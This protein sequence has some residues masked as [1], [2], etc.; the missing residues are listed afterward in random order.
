MRN[1]AKMEPV[2]VFPPRRV[3]IIKPSALGD[4]VTGMPILRGLRRSF[5]DAHLAWLIASPLA[6]VIAHDSDLDEVILFDRERLGKAWRSPGAAWA[7]RRLLRELKRGAFDWVIDLQGL[8]RS[9]LFAR[10]TRA[11]VRAGFADAREGAALFYTHRVPATAT[12][13]V[14]RNVELARALGVDAKPSDMTLQ[15]SGEARV[16]AEE[17]LD[18]EGLEPGGFWV[19]VAPTRWRTKLYPVRHWRK[20]AAEMARRMPVALL[21]APGDR[22]LCSRIADGLDPPVVNLCGRTGVA[23]LVAVIAASAGVVCS[24]SAA[25]FI[26]PAVGVRAVKLIGPTRVELTGPMPTGGR[27]I[28]ADVPCQGCLKHHCEHITCM[29]LIDPAEVAAAAAQMLDKRES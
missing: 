16:F 3:L 26:A 4:V 17:L 28:V 15:V 14:D 8:L 18:R 1:G 10:A 12:H 20:V 19:C 27:A 24:D 29:E 13:T 5:P 21:G 22:D 7:L 25:K 6:P 9:G 11:P 2:S 23:E